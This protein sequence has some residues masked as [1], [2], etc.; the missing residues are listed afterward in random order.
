MQVMLKVTDSSGNA[1][2]ATISQYQYN[3]PESPTSQYF[4]PCEDMEPNEDTLYPVLRGIKVTVG[5]ETCVIT[6]FALT[7]VFISGVS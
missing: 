3:D 4:A 5:S 1:V 7:L 2:E 6:E